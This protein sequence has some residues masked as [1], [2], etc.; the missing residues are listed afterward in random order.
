[1]PPRPLPTLNLE[2][3]TT[4]SLFDRPSKVGLT[5]LGRPLRSD[6][7]VADLVEGLPDQLAGRSLRRWRD[8]ICAARRAHCAVVAA[9]GGHV[10][11]TGCGPYLI[12]WIRRDVLTA[13]CLNGAAAIHDVELALAGRT[14]EDVDARLPDGSFGMTRET[15]QFFAEAV[16]IGTMKGFGLGAALGALLLQ[17]RCLHPEASLLRAAAEAGVPCTVHVALGTDIVHMH[18]CASGAQIGEATLRDFW[19]AC[20]I[21]ADLAGGVWMN[22][23]SAVLLPEVFLKAVSIARNLGFDLDGLTTVDLDMVRQY[24]AR[25]NV[26]ERH[27]CQAIAVTGHHELILPLIH[28]AVIADCSR[29]SAASLVPSS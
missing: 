20:A 3:L 27:H 1:M 9:L 2:Q 7:T 23:G 16:G 17:Q 22:I 5:H 19:Q 4:H 26:L 15:A 13:V 14:S 18:P 28:A 25:V 29:E 6:A 24:R 12:D 10:I 8:A 11:K 21:V